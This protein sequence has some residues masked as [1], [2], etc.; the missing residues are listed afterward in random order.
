MKSI[1]N[2]SNAEWQIMRVIWAAE[3]ATA[4]DVITRLAPST[5]WKPKTVMTMLRRL[6]D[7]GALRYE[8]NGRAYR[9]YPTVS[10]R[11]C[12]RAESKSFL[13]RVYDNDPAPMLVHFVREA[14]LSGK[15]IAELKRIL[16]EKASKRR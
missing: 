3:S 11:D 4:Q 15:D 13:K 10:E 6:V 8:K 9:Y 5:D 7:K 12:K 1:P 2:I 14:R 16:N